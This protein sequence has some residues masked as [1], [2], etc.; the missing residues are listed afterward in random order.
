MFHH[1]VLKSRDTHTF[2]TCNDKTSAM[3]NRT[4]KCGTI[5][6]WII[7]TQTEQVTDHWTEAMTLS[8]SANKKCVNFLTGGR[9]GGGLR[10]S[11]GVKALMGC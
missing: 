3:R 1:C 5:L 9:E 6:D 8:L 2:E 10:Y 4:R 7:T 11:Q